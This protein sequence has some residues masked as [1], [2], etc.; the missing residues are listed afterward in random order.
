LRA[1]AA[2]SAVHSCGIVVRFCRIFDEIRQRPW[3]NG[4]MTNQRLGLRVAG[5]IFALICVG[6]LF[7][8]AA[9]L[10]INIAGRAIPM[11]PSLLAAVVT[12]ALSIWMWALA[13]QR[14]EK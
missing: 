2:T 1:I 14:R 11:W 6:H 9:H 13:R 4:K 5:L 8:V 10:D 12:G 3:D 7:R